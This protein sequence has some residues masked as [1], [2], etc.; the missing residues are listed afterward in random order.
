MNSMVVPKLTRKTHADLCIDIELKPNNNFK[1]QAVTITNYY[2]QLN[3]SYYYLPTSFK[4]YCL[5]KL[6]NDS[7]KS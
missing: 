5:K 6:Q 2:F 1:I 7:K 3:V 4:N